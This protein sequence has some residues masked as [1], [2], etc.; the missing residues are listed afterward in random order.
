MVRQS[1]VRIYCAGL[2]KGEKQKL[3]DLLQPLRPLDYEVNIHL[4]LHLG[5]RK[6]NLD[7]KQVEYKSILA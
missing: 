4:G 1:F 6:P 3:S 2:E 5:P 7:D